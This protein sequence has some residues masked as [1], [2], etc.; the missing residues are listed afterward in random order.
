MK[1][2]NKFFDSKY[3]SLG[4]YYCEITS[5]LDRICNIN[6]QEDVYGTFCL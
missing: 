2:Y 4:E 5:E 6:I 1:L 3:S